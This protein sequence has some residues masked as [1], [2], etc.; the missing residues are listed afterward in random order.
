[1]RIICGQNNKYIQPRKKRNRH[2]LIS[3]L[4]EGCRPNHLYS[5]GCRSEGEGKLSWRII[6]ATDQDDKTGRGVV[7]EEVKTIFYVNDQ[8]GV[9]EWGALR[10]TISPRRCFFCD[11]K[12][13]FSSHYSS[14][15]LRSI[16]KSTRSSAIYIIAPSAM[17]LIR[18][19]LNSQTDNGRPCPLIR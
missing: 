4:A 14:I 18:N 2:Q 3:V 11:I 6:I 8:M 1:M 7:K 15:W 19:V 13:V 12:F 17:E 16:L 5:S 9:M 10:A